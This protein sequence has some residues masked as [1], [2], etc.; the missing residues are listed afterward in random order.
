MIWTVTKWGRVACIL[1]AGSC[2][3]AV[4]ADP[5]VG[6]YEAGVAAFK[7][8]RAD[9]PSPPEGVRE[10]MQEA[11]DALK[12]AMPAPG[13]KVGARAPE[14]TLGDEHGAPVSL[15]AALKHGPVI[16]TF[17]RGGWC[18]YCSAELNALQQSTEAFSRYA[19]SILAITPQKLDKSAE[20]QAAASFE[21]PLLSDLNGA[22]MKAYNVY[23][24]LPQ[25]LY[26]L[27]RDQFN[28]DVMEY[29]GDG[30]KGLPVPGTFVIDTNGII[31]AAFADTDYK[32]RMEPAEI[33]KALE[34]LQGPP[35]P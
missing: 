25:D 32:L 9:S 30:R 10:T 19:A 35:T 2:L 31:R 17:Y 5:Q 3:L 22:V 1:L 34:A 4:A 12:Q 13:L 23:F 29:N 7:E 33:L 11:A 16:L 21:F 24:E 28:F 15:Q 14:F 18:P 8:R 26:E 27:Y 20:Q 6:S